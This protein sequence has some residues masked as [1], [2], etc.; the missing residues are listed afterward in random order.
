MAEPPVPP[1]TGKSLSKTLLSHLFY[2][3]N[4]ELVTYECLC[5]RSLDKTAQFVHFWDEIP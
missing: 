1:L 3:I 4:D 2:L 5:A